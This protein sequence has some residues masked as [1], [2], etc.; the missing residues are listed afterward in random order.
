MS[1]TRKDV[2]YWVRL[3][4]DGIYTDHDH[5]RFGRIHYKRVYLYN[6]DNTPVMASEPVMR[7]VSDILGGGF[8]YF[9]Y[10][11]PRFYNYAPSGVYHSHNVY[12]FKTEN[13]CY[14]KDILS[15]AQRLNARGLTSYKLHVGVI[16]YHDY[17]KVEDSRLADHCTE[18]EKLLGP[19]SAYYMMPCTPE[20]P[21]GQKWW[22][23]GSTTAREMEHDDYY[24]YER[25][26]V[27]ART[28][29]LKKR[30]NSGEDV[31]DWDE[32]ASYTGTKRRY[33]FW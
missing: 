14:R 22:Y 1:R 31:D 19:D 23:Y 3:N 26:R 18:G 21:P 4:R 17:K 10:I 9:E 16:T 20:L 8:R 24:S 5:T 13:G 2:P 6:E 25:T 15:E 29:N 12:M 28:Q 27:R 7:S 30:W 32:D 33:T 11:Y